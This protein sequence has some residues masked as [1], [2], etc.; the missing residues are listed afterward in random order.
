MAARLSLR[1]P[2][3]LW[4]NLVYVNRHSSY[5]Y[6][7][8]HGWDISARAHVRTCRCFPF[9]Y[10]TSGWTDCAEI[11]CLV[12]HRL[13]WVFYKG[14][15]TGAVAYHFLFLWNGWTRCAEI[16]Y[17]VGRP[18]AVRFKQFMAWVSS[19]SAHVTTLFPFLENGRAQY[20]KIWCVVRGPPAMHLSRVTIEAHLY[21]LTCEPIFIS[22][23]PVDASG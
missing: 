16:R 4:P 9:P 22:R 18:L 11:W 21:V 15:Y 23:Q 19:A 2:G 14:L 17:V 13:A 20:D 5:A 7:T 12:R 3:R 8:G 6:C 10:P 1:R